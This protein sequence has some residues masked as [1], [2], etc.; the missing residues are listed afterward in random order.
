MTALCCV[1]RGCTWHCDLNAVNSRA[2]LSPQEIPLILKY[3]MLVP[4][5]EPFHGS[6]LH[7]KTSSLYILHS[8]NKASSPFASEPNLVLFYWLKQHQAEGPLVGDQLRWVS[9]ICVT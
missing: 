8:K 3:S 2:V 1:Q 5:W 7:N 4:H 9:S 6:V